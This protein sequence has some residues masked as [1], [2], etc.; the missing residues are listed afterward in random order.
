[1]QVDLGIDEIF[2]SY[3]N[4]E[5]FAEIN[6]GDKVLLVVRANHM[7]IRAGN[8]V[9]EKRNA[10]LGKILRRKF[11]GVFYRFEVLINNNGEEKVIIITVPAT[12]EIHNQFIEDLEV[13]V[14]FPKEL[15]ILFKHPGEKYIKKIIK[16][17]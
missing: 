3:I 10:F 8:R 6:H 5:K 4:K 11:M 9:K 17:E 13:T 2:A 12:S 16:L 15:G 1:M 7:K 14:Y